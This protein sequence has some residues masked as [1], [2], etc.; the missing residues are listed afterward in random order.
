MAVGDMRGL[1][2]V[3]TPETHWC[4]FANLKDWATTLPRSSTRFEPPNPS[5]NLYKNPAGQ[6]HHEAVQYARF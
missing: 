2:L 5:I 3:V 6:I 1:G 4:A